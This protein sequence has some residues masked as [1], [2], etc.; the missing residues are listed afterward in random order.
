MFEKR[1]LTKTLSVSSGLGLAFISFAAISSEYAISTGKD[2]PERIEKQHQDGEGSDGGDAIEKIVVKG[3]KRGTELL[4]ADVSVTVIDS[5][6][7][8]EARIRDFTRIDEL[9][10]NVQ[11]NESG[12]T[13]S[14]YITIRGVES[15]PFVVNRAAVYIDGIPF[16]ELSNSVLSQVDSI[17]VLRGP[18]G[19]LYGA[20]SESG[21]I[22]VTTK[23][24]SEVMEQNY[25]VSA[26]S[27]ASG[28]G[29]VG[30]G[31]V[32]GP[33]AQNSLSGSVAF[34][35]SMEDAY[36]KNEGTSTGESGEIKENFVQGK[37]QWTPTDALTINATS[38]WLD[39]DAPGLFVQQY[40]PLNINLYNQLYADTMNGER[41]IDKWTALEDAPKY[42]NSEEF[43]AGVSVTY[44]T[45]LGTIDLAASYRTLEE[46][47]K[48]LDFDLTATPYVS[49]REEK[50]EDYKNLEL[51]YSSPENIVFDYIVGMSYYAESEEN[52]KSTFMGS[53]DLDSYL[54]APLQYKEGEDKSLFGSL[55]WY[56]TD[57]LKFGAGLRYEHAERSAVQTAGALD[58]GLGAITYYQD[59]DLSNT[60]ENWLPRIS[61]LYQFNRNLS[62]HASVSK[63]YIPG[64]FNLTAIQDDVVDDSILFY[65]SETLLSREV[66]FKWMS[67]DRKWRS[68]GAL[69]FI[70]SDNWQE[71]QVATDANGRP[72]SSDYIGS[73]A[74]V[75]SKG[76][77]L[78]L[79]WRPADSL[80]INSHFGIVDAEY[81]DLQISESLN[82][83]GQA[84]Q[85]V[86]DYDAGVAVRY[87]LDENFYVRAEANFTGKTALRAKGDAV[88]RAVSTL[89]LQL[90]Y[91]GG[92]TAIR[93][94]G[95]NLTDERIASGLA[96][97]NMAFGTDGLFYSPLDA[98]RIIGVEVEVWL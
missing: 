57:K 17:E 76:A 5:K 18:Q 95:E 26:S 93:V 96:I 2:E 27:Y 91:D 88:Q 56:V 77:E 70:E 8:D 3:T 79:V 34:S 48:G 75:E 31:F 59:A 54:A 51:R 94:F 50:S 4:K 1:R 49:G 80:S 74:S 24:P 6:M 58:L 7:I 81:T 89:G 92:Q 45:G 47:S 63:G 72:V 86:P 19:T 12:Q 84:V 21:L 53:G 85:F 30:T 15:N 42:T 71:I 83:A 62:F 97:E 60:F 46:D 29:Y 66:G 35:T 13:G 22:L 73:A 25:R 33:L 41:Q 28:Q 90:G 40:V 69:F 43:V 64:G 11:F 82:A 20:N 78:E 38:Y 98:P 87:E 9:V 37:L 39:E 65:D 32:G 36:V 10:P 16:R 68:S 44:E 23:T 14:I 52:T 67:A 55:N 61:A